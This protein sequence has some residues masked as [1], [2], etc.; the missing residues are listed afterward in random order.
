[1]SRFPKPQKNIPPHG[2]QIQA[3]NK[4]APK[5]LTTS[6]RLRQL[7]TCRKVLGGGGVTRTLPWRV[8]SW[9]LSL[10]FTHSHRG[11]TCNNFKQLR[12]LCVMGSAFQIEKFPQVMRCICTR[13]VVTGAFSVITDESLPSQTIIQVSF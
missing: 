4:S 13:K 6:F 1:M 5:Q 12:L 2:R 9:C 3:E 10:W 11:L 8:S 7:L